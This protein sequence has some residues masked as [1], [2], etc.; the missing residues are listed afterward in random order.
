MSEWLADV[1]IYTDAGV[2]NRRGA[3][4]VV[5]VRAD[6]RGGVFEAS[7]I[8]RDDLDRSDLCEA[9]A[10]ANGVHAAIK[11]GLI[12]KG[13]RVDIRLDNLIVA[14]RFAGGKRAKKYRA[15][16]FLLRVALD[17]GKAYLRTAGASYK[18]AWIKGH[19]DPSDPCPHARMNRRADLL[20]SRELGLKRANIETGITD[21]QVRKRGELAAKSSRLSNLRDTVAR[22]TGAA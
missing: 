14:D 22:L 19:S 17:R 18:C 11:A 21:V 1:Q 8:L 7:G 15:S 12:V 13:D 9:R 6:G 2:K 20:C 4:A 3:W 5:A 16:D 10:L